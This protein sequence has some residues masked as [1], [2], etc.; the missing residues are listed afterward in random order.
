MSQRTVTEKKDGRPIS[1]FNI[2]T[3]TGRTSFA[4]WAKAQGIVKNKYGELYIKSPS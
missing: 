1:D 2:A 3:T 4:E